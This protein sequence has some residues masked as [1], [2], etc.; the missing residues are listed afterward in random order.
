E[1]L[2]RMREAAKERMQRRASLLDFHEA[3]LAIALRTAAL[4][5]LDPFPR[6]RAVRMPRKCI[7]E[8]DFVCAP[9]A[10]DLVPDHR[11]TALALRFRIGVAAGE[12]E[13]LARDEIRFLQELHLGAERDA[14]EAAPAMARRLAHQHHARAASA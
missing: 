7:P 8:H 4:G 1:D 6:R 9:G 5:A 11:G 13:R 12:H 10:L 2:Q 14:A 3:R